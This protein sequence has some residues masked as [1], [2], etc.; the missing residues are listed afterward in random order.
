ME[1]KDKFI[2]MNREE[3]KDY[4]LKLKLSRKIERLQNHHTYIPSYKDFKN[5]NYFNLLIGMEI[6]HIQRGFEEIAQNLTIFPDG[7]VALCRDLN[8][9][10]AGIKGANSGSICIE[11]LG[12]F[13]K[14]MDIMTP[15]QKASI[16]YINALLCKK[17]NLKP[18]TQTIIYHHW[19]DLES[20]DRTRDITKTKSCPGTNFF[21]GNT[22][23]AAQKNF[24]PLILSQ[25][26]SLD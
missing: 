19:Y 15:D 11:N 17:F 7:I 18:D 22:L 20:G 5:K 16:I 12:N 6:S 21:S 8:K 24:L 9:T 25:I 26:K 2:L 14:G 1:K 4:I 23:E 10:P 3:F 13:D